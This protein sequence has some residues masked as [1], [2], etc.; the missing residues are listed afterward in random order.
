MTFA[1]LLMA[2]VAILLT[3]WCGFEA[4]D[5]GRQGYRKRALSIAALGGALLLAIGLLWMGGR[6]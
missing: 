6:R 3:M 1:H 5:S 2:G 4:Y